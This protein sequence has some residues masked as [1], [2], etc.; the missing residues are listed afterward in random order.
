MEKGVTVESLKKEKKD[1]LTNYTKLLDPLYMAS[2]RHAFLVGK[3]GVG[4][5]AV[6]STNHILNTIAGS[7]LKVDSNQIKLPHNTK[8]TII[9]EDGKEITKVFPNLA[10]VKD[11]AGNWISDNLSEFINAYVDVAKDPFIIK[12]NAGIENSG[13]FM[14]MNK[15]GTLMKTDVMKYSKNLFGF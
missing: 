8:V 13:V 9:T 5:G 10:L 11:K 6:N 7:Y 3:G 14:F 15:I 1:D 2:T 12:L 4:I